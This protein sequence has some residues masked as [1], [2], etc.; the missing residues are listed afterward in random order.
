M[1]GPLALLV[2]ATA[3]FASGLVWW[4]VR[5]RA[6]EPLPGGVDLEQVQGFVFVGSGAL[7]VLGVAVLVLGLVGRGGPAEAMGV[8]GLI[9]YLVYLLVAVVL[10]RRTARRGARRAANVP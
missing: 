3:L 8:L 7:A 9:A 10:I 4:R 6:A 1:Y 5:R 2:V